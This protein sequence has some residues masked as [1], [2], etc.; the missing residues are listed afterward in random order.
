L[1]RLGT[2]HDH[3]IFD[4]RESQ[5]LLSRSHSC[6]YAKS[7]DPIAFISITVTNSG[8]LYTDFTHLLFLHAH[9]EVRALANEIP[10]ESHPLRGFHIE[11]SH[12]V[13]QP[14]SEVHMKKMFELST[15]INELMGNDHDTIFVMVNP[16]QENS[17]VNQTVKP[18]ADGISPR[19]H[20]R[21]RGMRS[22]YIDC[23]GIR[24][25]SMA[26]VTGNC[27]FALATLNPTPSSFCPNF[28]YC[29][30]RV[31]WPFL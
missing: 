9:R 8:R 17:W 20:S 13:V 11:H 4:T 19:D 23:P 16:S 29:T 12:E 15:H 24:W 7:P 26:T 25:Y 21:P 18:N 31:F 30:G 14:T 10:E 2:P 3:F 22:L 1:R 5:T 6:V 27:N 28:T